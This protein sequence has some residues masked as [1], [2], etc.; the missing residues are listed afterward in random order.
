MRRATQPIFWDDIHEELSVHPKRARDVVC[1]SHKGVV[2]SRDVLHALTARR[3]HARYAVVRKRFGMWTLP[4]SLPDGWLDKILGTLFSLLP[5]LP[6][7]SSTGAAKKH[8]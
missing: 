4:L 5:P 1:L 8:L 6:R 7:P 2:K 3:P